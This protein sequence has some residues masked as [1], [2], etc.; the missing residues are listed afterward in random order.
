MG[1]TRTWLHVPMHQSTAVE[2]LQG[3]EHTARAV[4]ELVLPY[5]LRLHQAAEV[6][7]QQ[8]HHTQFVLREDHECLPT[9]EQQCTCIAWGLDT[10][11]RI[12]YAAA[13]ALHGEL[14]CSGVLRADMHAPPGSRCL[15]P[16]Q[17]SH[18]QHYTVG[19]LIS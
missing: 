4:E 13:K 2:S 10:L 8:L 17:I 15:G 1:A 16:R 12:A 5:Q 11:R 3:G 19:L 7:P 14:F 6:R 18:E 9:T